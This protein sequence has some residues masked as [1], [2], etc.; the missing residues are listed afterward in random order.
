VPG[1]KFL[2]PIC[3]VS[4]IIYNTFHIICGRFE[5]PGAYLFGPGSEGGAGVRHQAEEG[6]EGQGAEGP[7]GQQRVST[8]LWP[9]Q[10]GQR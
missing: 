9:P 10:G 6:G 8:G 3:I 5:V 7:A 1:L 2:E 4:D